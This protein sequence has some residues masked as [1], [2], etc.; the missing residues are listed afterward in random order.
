[1]LNLPAGVVRNNVGVKIAKAYKFKNIHIYEN[2]K[3]AIQA[4][5]DKKN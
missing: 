5:I 1:M 4:L 3:S 2:T